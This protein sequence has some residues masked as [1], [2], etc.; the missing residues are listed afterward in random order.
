M[1]LTNICEV[2]E[3]VE[4][5]TSYRVDSFEY[6]CF[7]ILD[8]DTASTSYLTECVK[9]GYYNDGDN[10]TFMFSGNLFFSNTAGQHL[11]SY[12]DYSADKQYMKNQFHPNDM[13]LNFADIE[14][15]GNTVFVGYVL[16]LIKK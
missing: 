11:V 9:Q 12:V 13:Y 4:Q 8:A 3:W 7:N 15:V 6:V 1:Q 16:R 10:K 5:N 2:K 14:V